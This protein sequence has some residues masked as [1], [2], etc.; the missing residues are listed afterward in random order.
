MKEI[1]KDIKGF[2]GIY[3]VSNIGNVKSIYTNKLIGS[4]CGEGDSYGYRHVVLWKDGEKVKDAKVHRLVAKAFIP[5]PK[6]KPY[7]NHINAIRN[8]NRVSNLEWCTHTENM[9]HAWKIGNG[10]ISE[11]RRVRILTQPFI[12]KMK[13]NKYIGQE[14]GSIKI[15]KITSFRRGRIKADVKCLRCLKIYL[16]KNILAELK[17]VTRMCISCKNK[18]IG[19]HKKYKNQMKI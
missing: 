1:F 19:R 15:L 8:D 4:I 13:Y 16:D 11:A 10:T 12:A 2:E 5:N 9:Q 3:K 18:S 17:G 7:I 6:N 14:F